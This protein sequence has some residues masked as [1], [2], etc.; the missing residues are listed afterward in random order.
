MYTFHLKTSNKYVYG[1]TFFKARRSFFK[2]KEEKR[3]RK[4]VDKKH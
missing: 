1:T 2:K 4:Q 3:K